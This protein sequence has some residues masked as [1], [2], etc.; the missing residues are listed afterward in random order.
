MSST[1]ITKNQFPRKRFVSND[2]DTDKMKLLYKEG[3]S[4]PQIAE[5]IGCSSLT[6]LNTLRSQ[7]IEIRSRGTYPKKIL[8]QKEKIFEEYENGDSLSVI[9]ER[10]GVNPNTVYYHLK[11]NKQETRSNRKLSKGDVDFIR[12]NYEDN[13]TKDRVRKLS[14]KFGVTPNDIRYHI[15]KERK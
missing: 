10:Y 1:K 12:K 2:D 3:K 15:K 13:P 9:A 11:K 7:G 6:V 4:A 8:S 5:E 14:D